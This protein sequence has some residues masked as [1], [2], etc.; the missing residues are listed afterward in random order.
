MEDSWNALCF[1]WMR[2]MM[3]LKNEVVQING[4]GCGHVALERLEI[5]REAKL[6]S[7]AVIM[8]VPLEHASGLFLWV[9]KLPPLSSHVR[10]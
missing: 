2:V 1:P 3:Q 5:E 8:M 7:Q 10:H 4:M 6:Q 9:I